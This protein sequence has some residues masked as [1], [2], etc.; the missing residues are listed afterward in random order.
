MGCVNAGRAF[1]RHLKVKVEV[2]SDYGRLEWKL[3]PLAQASPWPRVL[4]PFLYGKF[5]VIPVFPR[6]SAELDTCTNHTFLSPDTSPSS[7][8]F[9]HFRWLH[10]QLRGDG[11]D[12]HLDEEEPRMERLP[13]PVSSPAPDTPSRVLASVWKSSLVT[14]DI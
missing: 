1:S 12:R 3:L 10:R 9:T 6:L 5:W 7:E 14:D 8:S 13:L 2:G 11:S 4:S